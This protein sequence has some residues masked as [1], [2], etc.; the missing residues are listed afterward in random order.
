MKTLTPAQFRKWAEAHKPLAMAVCKTM[1][2]A[3]VEHERVNEYVR[4]IFQKY[5]FVDENGAPIAGPDDVFLSPDDAMC[6]AFWAECDVAHRAHGWIGPEGNCPALM[7]ENLRATAEN[8]LLEAGCEFLGV[9]TWLLYGD[10]RK[11]ML[12]LLLKAC[13]NA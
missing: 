13:L 4:P 2:F 8:A 7:A 5:R 10:N 6:K 11:E 12:D 1:A 3:T 9:K